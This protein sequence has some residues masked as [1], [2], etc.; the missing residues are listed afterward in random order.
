MAAI[1]YARQRCTQRLWLARI[2]ER[3]P[4]TS[5]RRWDVVEC[6]KEQ[7]GGRI[8]AGGI[9]LID[10]LLGAVG[11]ELLAVAEPA[12]GVITGQ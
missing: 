5:I 6:V 9:G 10:S 4:I 1:R 3:Q 12:L 7:N 8:P 11:T 2:I